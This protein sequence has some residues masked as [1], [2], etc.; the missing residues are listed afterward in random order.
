MQVCVCFKN[1]K[2]PIS[3]SGDKLAEVLERSLKKEARVHE[4]QN[5][6]PG[7]GA[8]PKGAFAEAVER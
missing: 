2:W 3:Q 5:F 1:K 6:Q 8:I 7:V 4:F